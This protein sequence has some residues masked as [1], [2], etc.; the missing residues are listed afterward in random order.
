MLLF[1]IRKILFYLSSFGG[2]FISNLY[3]EYSSQMEEIKNSD[4][5]VNSKF[6]KDEVQK[7]I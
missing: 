6:V 4:S 5:F 7:N 3:D 1:Q 2:F